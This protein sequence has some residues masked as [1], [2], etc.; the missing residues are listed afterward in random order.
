MS[1]NDQDATGAG[2]SVCGAILAGG[3]SRRFGSDKAEAEIGGRRLIDLV[4]DRLASQT[5]ALVICGRDAP[6]RRS[7][8]DKPE[9]GL[10]PLGG[11]LA[12]LVYAAEQDH[13]AVLS[14]GCDAFGLPSDLLAQ[15]QG[16]GPAICEAQPVIGYWPVGIA[17][18]LEA[19]LQD[20]GRAVFGFADS[21]GARRVT[22]DPPPRNINRPGDLDGLSWSR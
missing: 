6:G 18:Q 20:G 16:D 17:P 7:L 13:R 4:A 1:G 2:P 11:L 14:A 5:D 9:P 22:L 12:A 15:L 10:G 21:V 8:E 19:F 3:E